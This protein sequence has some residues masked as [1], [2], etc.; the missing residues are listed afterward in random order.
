MLFWLAPCRS[1]TLR[2]NR[3]HEAVLQLF[4][5]SLRPGDRSRRQFGVLVAVDGLHF[6]WRHPRIWVRKLHAVIGET[7]KQHFCVDHGVVFLPS[8]ALAACAGSALGC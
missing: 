3:A 7:A 1:L 2:P 6:F 8:S 5:R 4:P